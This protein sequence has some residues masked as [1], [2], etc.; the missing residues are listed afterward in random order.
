MKIKTL[1]ITAYCFGF[2]L[3]LVLY[4]F[5]L[6]GDYIE[7]T[8]SPVVDYTYNGYKDKTNYKTNNRIYITCRS[9]QYT[10]KTGNR[11][12]DIAVGFIVLQFFVSFY[13]FVYE[14][15]VRT[16]LLHFVH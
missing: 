3:S 14:F 11:I 7:K 16:S 1:F 15:C 10:I 9:K 8:Q 6:Y 12:L 4:L 13:N 5:N 2:A